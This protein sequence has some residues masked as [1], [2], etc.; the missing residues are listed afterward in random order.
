MIITSC[1]L[2]VKGALPL[3]VLSFRKQQRVNDV[4]P[5]Q[6]AMNDCPKYG[7]VARPGDYNSYYGAQSHARSHIYRLL[8]CIA[9]IG[10]CR[11]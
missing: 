7:L 8:V 3:E 5:S 4:Q 10:A 11:A 1:R 9:A 2:I 6:N